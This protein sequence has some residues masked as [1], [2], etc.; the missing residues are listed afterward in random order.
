MGH[1]TGTSD[2]PLHYGKAPAWLFERMRK[3]SREI[4]L[5]LVES[6][7]AA[8]IL[9]RLSD[10]FW[11]QAFGC[12]LGFDWH[13][14]GLTTTVCGALKEAVAELNE[15]I[16]LYIAGGKGKTSRRTPEE[17]ERFSEK[18]G[19]DAKPLL[20][21]SRMSAK[22]DS[23]AVQDGYQIYH[24]MFAFDKNGNWCV[25][26]QGMNTSARVAR[27]Y[28]WLSFEIEDFVCEPH[29][30]IC[31]EKRGN[32][33]NMVALESAR[34][35]E[36][37]TEIS[38]EKPE[39][40]V[41]ELKRT[42]NLDLPT[43]HQVMLSDINVDRIGSILTSTYERQPEDFEA[44]LG[45]R[46]VGPK[47]IR[48]LAL[49]SEIVYG[50]KPSM[51]DPARF[52]FAHGGKDGHPYPVDRATYD[53]SIYFLENAIREAKLGRTEKIEAFKRLYSIVQRNA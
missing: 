3:L 44:L 48:A 35:R 45:M 11:F 53:M 37:V 47:T 51:R 27:R 41:R 42:E 16:G 34:A 17:I 38:R 36:V 33:L 15:E 19:L 46:G 20:Y 13:S 31:C 8:E 4:I 26:Q 12:V 24:H 52:S 28:H 29:K 32:T 18:I 5:A 9:K 30:A 25:V 43:R 21:A 22:V 23:A 7:G 14:S 39:Q 50:A 1:R 10:P 6:Y 2:L 40:V 49:L